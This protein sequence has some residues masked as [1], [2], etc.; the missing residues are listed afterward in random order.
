MRLTNQNLI[1]YMVASFLLGRSEYQP[2]PDA[3]KTQ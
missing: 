2:Q 3:Q 1:R